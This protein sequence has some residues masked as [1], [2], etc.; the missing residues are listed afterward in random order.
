[1]FVANI[2]SLTAALFAHSVYAGVIASQS[3]LPYNFTL[4]ALNSSLP[5]A[6]YTGAPLVLGQNGASTGVS[7]YV[8]STH[9]SYPYNDYPT[10]ALRDN[11]LKAYRTSGPSITNATEVQSGGEL[12]WITTTQG[13]AGSENYSVIKAPAYRF[14]VLAAHGIHDLWSLCP[15]QGGQT[16]VVFNV[17]TDQPNAGSDPSQCYQVIINV[18]PIPQSY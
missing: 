3:S 9:A 15:F 13:H 14:P 2:L 11:I 4:A 18:V 1:M 17:S 7:F 16:N 5:N 10:L 12:V 8:T 6:N